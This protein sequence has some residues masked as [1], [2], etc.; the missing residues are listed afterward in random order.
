MYHNPVLE[1]LL[2]RV[3]AEDA[4]FHFY[5]WD[6]ERE[7]VVGGTLSPRRGTET[8]RAC[9]TEE[10]T[11]S[12]RRGSR[13]APDPTVRLPEKQAQGT[14]RQ[15]HDCASVVRATDADGVC[16]LRW[17]QLNVDDRRPDV[18]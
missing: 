14:H 1:R 9:P 4:E 5:V 2:G 7:E 8:P 6:D 12:S 11:P 18:R 10:S 13:R 16:Q 3:I 17:L 15:E